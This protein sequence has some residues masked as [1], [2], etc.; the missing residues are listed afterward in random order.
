[1]DAIHEDFRTVHS[2]KLG[3]ALRSN[4][5]R[6]SK[7]LIRIENIAGDYALMR[8]RRNKDYQEV[9]SEQVLLY[10]GSKSTLERKR[11][12]IHPHSWSPELEDQIREFEDGVRGVLGVI[13]AAKLTQ[14]SINVVMDTCFGIRLRQRGSVYFVSDLHSSKLDEYI[15]Q[16]EKLGVQ[17]FLIDSEKTA[18]TIR[19]V[20]RSVFADVTDRLNQIVANIVDTDGNL[21]AKTA[22][23]QGRRMAEMAELLKIA[24]LYE[25]VLDT[26]M[27]NLTAQITN[28]ET[29]VKALI[30]GNSASLLA[31]AAKAKN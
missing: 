25:K 27:D 3:E 8:I 10:D 29:V 12:D 11:T 6:S 15:K 20:E 17:V 24:R 30:T 23:G 19:S 9:K 4:E 5:S 22:K 13:S 18:T 26:K 14:N 31:A 16:A 1:V 7:S 21:V 28:T 2:I